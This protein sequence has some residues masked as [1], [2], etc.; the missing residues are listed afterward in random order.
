MV[1]ELT[2]PVTYVGLPCLPFCFGARWPR[3]HTSKYCENVKSPG[4][5]SFEMRE[6]SQATASKHRSPHSVR[7]RVRVRVRVGWSASG[8]A[9]QNP[10][11]YVPG[12]WYYMP[13]ARY[14][15]ILVVHFV[16]GA[17]QTSNYT[18]PGAHI[19]PRP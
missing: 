19:I 1:C 6:L 8:A 17:F 2:T 12:T 9:G 5:A 4:C 14:V 7:V 18:H 11:Q 3:Y 13:G 16:V 10:P 15:R